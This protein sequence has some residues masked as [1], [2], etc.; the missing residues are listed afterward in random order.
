MCALRPRE[1]Q[2]KINLKM[3]PCVHLQNPKHVSSLPL[4]LSRSHS[5]IP[6]CYFMNLA[7]D[8]AHRG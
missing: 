5:H 6:V 2:G 4:V 8:E 7:R 1:P 3:G